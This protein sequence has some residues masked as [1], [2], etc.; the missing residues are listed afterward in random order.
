MDETDKPA[1]RTGAKVIPLRCPGAKRPTEEEE[2]GVDNKLAALARSVV[3]SPGYTPSSPPANS[4]LHSA[5]EMLS[6]ADAA[7]DRA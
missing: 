6:D 5:L 3:S 2:R 1:E 4:S 7:G